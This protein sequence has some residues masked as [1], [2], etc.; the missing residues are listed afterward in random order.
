[1]FW[2]GITKEYGGKLLVHLPNLPVVGLCPKLLFIL[3]I[4]E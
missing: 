1:M 4:Y 3:N 2:K